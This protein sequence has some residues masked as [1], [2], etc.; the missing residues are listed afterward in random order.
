MS[1]FHP[2]FANSQFDHLPEQFTTVGFESPFQQVLQQ[3]RRLLQTC[4][5]KNKWQFW[6]SERPM[7]KRAWLDIA[8]L[9][10]QKVVHLANLKDENMV[11]TIEKALLSKNCSYVVA[12]I[13]HLNKQEKECLQQAVLTSGTPLFLVDEA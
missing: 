5:K 10:R 4:N 12:C 2:I 8:G 1:L 13:H 7:L 11:T 9:D 3:Q 6:L